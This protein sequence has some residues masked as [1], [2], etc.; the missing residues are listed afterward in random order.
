MGFDVTASQTDPQLGRANKIS[1]GG[2]K[3]NFPGKKR[4]V[5]KLPTS[6]SHQNV[7]PLLSTFGPLV[8]FSSEDDE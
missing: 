5:R 4:R 1:G 8:H 2:G 7:Q 3:M 6:H